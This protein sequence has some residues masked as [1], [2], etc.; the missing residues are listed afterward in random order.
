MQFSQIIKKTWSEIDKIIQDFIKVFWG[1]LLGPN[2]KFSAGVGV[3]VKTENLLAKQ[4]LFSSLCFINVLVSKI[5]VQA[6]VFS[7]C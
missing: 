6:Q 2:Y 3:F 1:K 4:H 7:F 5:S